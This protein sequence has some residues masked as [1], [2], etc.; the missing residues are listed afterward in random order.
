MTESEEIQNHK[1]LY[2]SLVEIIK[3]RF[4]TTSLGVVALSGGVDS[5]LVAH[6][7]HAAL[8]D[9]CLAV[10]VQSEFTTP[11]DFTRAVEISELIGIEHHP[12]IMRM[13]AD[14]NVRRNDS[15]RCFHCKR[16]I[17]R[18]MRF[19]Y[20]DHCLFMDGTNADDDLERPGRKALREFGVFSPLEK[21]GLT[22][23]MVRQLARLVGLP[24]WDTPSE[25]CLATRLPVGTP[26]DAEGLERVR[27]MENFF[28]E[29]GVDTLRAYHDNLMA[30]VTFKPE[31]ADIMEKN[32]DNFMALITRLGLR[33]FIYKI[34]NEPDAD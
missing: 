7:A 5:A 18:M 8:G 13:L 32:R 12:L 25:S 10:T 34:W 9:K 4:D 33:S 16:A 11:R 3:D 28:H 19:E 15:E 17:F 14:E 23:S 27:L 24:N 21:A 31:Y 22:K 26:L 6:A 1:S 20:G 29:R 30:T 2:D